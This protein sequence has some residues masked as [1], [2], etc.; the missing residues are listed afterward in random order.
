[1]K[2]GIIGTGNMG[3]I[4]AEALI[5]GGAVS[6]SD[7]IVTNRTKSKADRLKHMYSGITV[8]G[9]PDSVIMGSE[10]IFICVKP[11]DIISLTKE[12]ASLFTREKC[13]VS[14]TS[15][16]Q[17]PWLEEIV[18]S[19]C[20]R[21]IPSITNRALAGVSLFTF[22]KNCDK[23][24]K[25]KLWKMFSKISVPLEIEEEIIRVSSD[26]VSCGPAFFSFL[27]R[28]LIEAAVD[29]TKI[30]EETATM[31]SENMLIGLG[32]L[33]KQKHYT[34][35]TLQEKV[36]VKGGITGEGIAVLKREKGEMF[37]KLFRATHQ[38][39]ENETLYFQK[40]FNL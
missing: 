29:E 27:T 25:E 22:G 12:K 24:W 40:K 7:L 19:S 9:S 31:L 1:M 2:V 21:I 38:K 6:P 39:F 13:L 4:L 36:C 15:P 16:I 17:V 11:A 35:P 5:T 37:N 23:H 26:I 28:S 3:S 14:I 32:E 34:L 33:L 20:A 18:E 30:D 8:L 10:I